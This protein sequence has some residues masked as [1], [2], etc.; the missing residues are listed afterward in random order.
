VD[1]GITNGYNDGTFRPD[2]RLSRGDFAVLL[3]RAFDPQPRPERQQANVSQLFVDVVAN[4]PQTK[5][6]QQIY[7]SGIMSGLPDRQ[8]GVR[9]VI[10]R[11]EAITAVT[12]VLEL[13]PDHGAT[14]RRYSDHREIPTWATGPIADATAAGLIV[15]PNP[16]RIRATVPITRAEVASLI[17]QGWRYKTQ[18]T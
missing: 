12:K 5:F 8:F 16:D 10:S 2:L 7:R 18:K 4:D 14:H 15:D 1:Q 3:V 17:Y 13:P 9:A 6:I 11:A